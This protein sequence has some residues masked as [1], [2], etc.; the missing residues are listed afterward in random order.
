MEV[1]YF[2]FL[3][4]F[5]GVKRFTLR[6]TAGLRFAAAAGTGA[7]LQAQ[8]GPA[9]SA[10]AAEHVSCGLCLPATSAPLPDSL[11]AGALAGLA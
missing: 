9:G 11:R 3:F 1:S 4:K 10:S 2:A 5:S 7:C 6:P 8:G